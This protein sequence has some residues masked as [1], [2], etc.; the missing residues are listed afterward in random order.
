MR[1][2]MRACVAIM[3]TN[4]AS[5]TFVICIVRMEQ[6]ILNSSYTIHT[7]KLRECQV[8]PAEGVFLRDMFSVNCS[9]FSDTST[10]LT[11]M[12]Y[13]DPGH[14]MISINGETITRTFGRHNLTAISNSLQ[15]YNWRYMVI[16]TAM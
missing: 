1:A 14:D 11:Y 13:M 6:L 16:A 4:I 9:L 5:V 3:L 12:F 7:A 8:T 10:P 2:C 15:T